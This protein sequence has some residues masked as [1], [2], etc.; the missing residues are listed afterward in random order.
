MDQYEDEREI[1]D[2]REPSGFGAPPR[3]G[4]G[5]MTAGP[6]ID[7][8]Y[9]ML[10][11]GYPRLALARLRGIPFA[12]IM[13]NVRGTITD[14]TVTSVPGQGNDIKI[15]QDTIVDAMMTRI[16]IDRAPTNVFQTASD[17][18][19]N[20]QSGLEATLD[21]TGSPK[22]PIAP[23]PTPLATL[24]DVFNGN[25]KWSFGHVLTY[26][27]AFNMSFFPRIALPDFPVTIVCSWRCWEPI[28]DMFVQMPNSQAIE[29]L[30]K[31][32]VFIPNGYMPAC[33]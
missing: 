17:Y 14:A 21:V 32:G 9:E 12:P 29:L 23:K 16:T 18:Y 7:P 31:E 10:R 3:T 8:V 5:L 6:L 20:F 27:Q 24:M 2:P 28:G 26:Q 11:L 1:Q 25:S 19:L 13:I 15:V 22:Y 33:R 30:Q 4:L